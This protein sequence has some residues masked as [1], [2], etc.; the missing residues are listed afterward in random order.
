MNFV[1][2]NFLWAFFLLAIPIIIHLFN[3][4]RY[5]T[6]YFSRVKFLEEVIEDSKSGLKLKH[7][8]VLFSRL[9]AL[10]AL[11]LAFAQPYIP[12]NDKK[13]TENITS[14]YIDNTFSM[15]AEGQDGNLLNEVKNKAID[16]VKSLDQN[17]RINLVTNDLLSIHQ[18]FYAKADIIEMIKKIDFSANSTP[19][20]T[21]ISMQSDLISNAE[22]IGNERLFLFSDFQKSTNK[23]EDFESESLPTHFYKAEVEQNANV[24]IDSIWFQSPVHRLN[25]PSDVYF[26][27]KNNADKAQDNLGIK[28]NIN[29]N[30]VGMKRVTIPANAVITDKITYTDRVSGSKK[31]KISIAS[32]QLFFDDE[33]YFTYNIK[34]SVNILIVQNKAE[35]NNNLSQ[36]YGLNSFY[37]A[38]TIQSDIAAPEN[39]HGKEL[40]IFQNINNL[41][42]G[43][44]SVIDE[45]VEKGG[46]VMLIPGSK[47][48]LSNW[49]TIMVK[50][51]LPLFSQLDTN[52]LSVNYFN[53]ADPL[54]SGVFESAP[55]NYKTPTIFGQYRLQS[56]TRNNYLSLFGTNKQNTAVF[57]TPVKNGKIIVMTSPLNIK[58]SNFQNHPLFA[59]MMLRI[60][61]T[62]T[63]QV[64]IAYTIGDMSNFPFINKIA[65][66]KP[67][68]LVNEEYSIDVIPEIINTGNSLV[69][70]FNHL[71]NYLS[72]AGFY[73]LGDLN[74][75]NTNLGLNYSREESDISAYDIDQIKTN[76]ANIGWEN[77][78]SFTT[79]HEGTIEINSLKA[80][81]YW[82]ILLIL[83]LVFIAFEI[84]LLKLWKG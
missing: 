19:L 31:A 77:A 68:H 29:G 78:N 23:L 81:E 51:Q 61:E 35:E 74:E 32:N 27:I 34:D 43:I 84:L 40:V 66:D 33:F 82:R 26:R 54:F 38:E 36:L 25:S 69:V 9:L 4:R 11:I 48:N 39:F 73:Y 44:V 17:E 13:A 2:P 65:E 41:P 22:N 21:V 50:N 37:N 67:I 63:F 49:N 42:S 5:K 15:Q 58:Y 47:L 55:K 75:F 28:L 53:H 64:P 56:S 12:T 57:Y 62:S 83:A 24:Y 16:L 14:I 3:F 30:E 46:T 18:R 52:Q 80:N 59:T 6:V 1:Y 60:A 71:E 7:L 79:N 72:R 45:I 10:S 70:S 76:F 8:L 20:Q